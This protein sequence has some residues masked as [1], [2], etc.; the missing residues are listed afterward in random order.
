V[1]GVPLSRL[2]MGLT[3]DSQTLLTPWAGHETV[4]VPARQPCQHSNEGEVSVA[5]SRPAEYLP[6]LPGEEP[7]GRRG[8]GAEPNPNLQSKDHL[9]SDPSP[10]FAAASRPTPGRVKG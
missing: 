7:A 4:G 6:S 5:G 10:P 9:G 1:N 3:V 2:R 8:V